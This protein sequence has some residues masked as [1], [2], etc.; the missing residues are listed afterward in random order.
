MRRSGWSEFARSAKA[1]LL[2]YRRRKRA[3]IHLYLKLDAQ[4]KKRL[5]TESLDRQFVAGVANALVQ[6]GRHTPFRV[7]VAI[8]MRFHVGLERTPPQIHQLPKH[9]LD[10]L[11]TPIASRARG[12]SPLMLQND[13]LVQALF[14]SCSFA[15]EEPAEPFISFEV[16][17]LTNFARDIELYEKIAR[18]DF[19]EIEGIRRLGI[20][21]PYDVDCEDDLCEDSIDEYRRLLRMGERGREQYGEELYEALLLMNKHSAQLEILKRRELR[22]VDIA[23]LYGPILR[24][25]RNDELFR[26]LREVSAANVRLVSSFGVACADL[27]PPAARPGDSDIVKRKV[28]AALEKMRNQYPILN[29]LL[30]TVGITLLYVRPLKAQA[31]DLDNLARRFVVPIVHEELKPPATPL[32]AIRQLRPDHVDDWVV[33]GLERIRR[34]H[35]VQVTRYQVFALPRIQ[36]DPPEGKIMVLIHGGDEI[37]RRWSTYRDELERWEKVVAGIR[38]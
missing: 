15:D 33:K 7:P 29:P 3:G 16:A 31:V 35:N 30:T 8:Q 28:R 38:D 12:R 14:C 2:D 18:G 21:D 32:H 9:Y 25:R 26:P 6:Q 19:D 36:D 23:T 20:K 4:S 1:E 37:D 13:R 24:R 10:L 17:T 5:N 34:A 22:P 11:Q 27:G